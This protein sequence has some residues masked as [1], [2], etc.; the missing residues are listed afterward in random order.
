MCDSVGWWCMEGRLPEP[1]GVCVCVGGHVGLGGLAD[2]VPETV[3]C[4]HPA[5]LPAGRLAATSGRWSR[6]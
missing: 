1:C 6:S 4:P 5:R 2:A 3:C